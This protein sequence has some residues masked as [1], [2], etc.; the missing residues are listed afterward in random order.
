MF[1]EMARVRIWLRWAG[2]ELAAGAA[3]AAAARSRFQAVRGVLQ[4]GGGGPVPRVDGEPG[5][6]SR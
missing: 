5:P 2:G 3:S 6:G 1:E 4:A